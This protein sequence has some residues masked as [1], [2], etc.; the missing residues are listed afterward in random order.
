MNG[1][2]HM[3]EF[4]ILSFIV[5]YI[6]KVFT[7][8]YKNCSLVFLKIMLFSCVFHFYFVSRIEV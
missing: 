8:V 2:A 4:D 1:K 5:K 3:G 7:N 6:F